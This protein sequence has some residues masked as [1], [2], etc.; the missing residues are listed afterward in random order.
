MKTIP[1]IRA[2]LHELPTQLA[3]A[4]ESSVRPEFLSAISVELHTLAEETKRKPSVRPRERA[5]KQRM[6]PAV[7]AKMRAFAA[8]PANRHL[9]LME[10]AVIFN[11][12]HGRVSE[13]INVYRDR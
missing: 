10:I 5:H 8:D 11:T 13:A 2:R 4:S 6:S 9:G 3:E 12:D 7:R 1:V